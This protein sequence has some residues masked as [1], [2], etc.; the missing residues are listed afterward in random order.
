MLPILFLFSANVALS[1]H[2]PTPKTVK[3]LYVTIDTFSDDKLMSGIK[4]ICK[5]TSINTLVI[6]VRSNGINAFTIKNSKAKNKLEELHSLNL[7]LVARIIVFWKPKGWFD[8]DSLDRWKQVVRS[9]KLAID[10]GFDEINYDYVRYGGP[11]EPKSSTPIAQRE[12]N[13]KSFFSYLE[14]E[15]GQKL[16]VPISVDI[17]G[18]TFLRP[19][20]SIGQ[21]SQD[22]AEYFNFIMPMVYPSHWASGTFG[23][24]DP[25]RA[26]YEVVYKSLSEGWKNI[27]KDKN[28]K[29]QL[30][31]WLQAFGLDSIFPFKTM[32]Y[33]SGEIKDQI[34]A[35]YDARCSGWV[36]W[37]PSSN[38][39]RFIDALK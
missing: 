37:N 22:A 17:F 5:E 3:G 21:K 4:N 24:K 12:A 36:L 14:K 1:D 19:E 10:L 30:R 38:Y 18:T 16:S 6:D 11:R 35:C 20:A 39:N 26:S 2:L 28:N 32:A 25:G 7:Y 33:G 15:V 29:S 34:R 9:S 8:P 23:I 31:P 27:S 13:I